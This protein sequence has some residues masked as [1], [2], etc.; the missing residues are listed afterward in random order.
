M[1]TDLASLG[2]ISLGYPNRG[3]LFNGVQM[4]ESDKWA[5]TER[6]AAYGTQETIDSIARAIEKVHAKHPNSDKVIIGHLSTKSGGRLKPHKSHQAGRDVDLSYFYTEKVGW[7]AYATDKNLDRARTWTFVKAFLEDPNTEM[8]L[9]DTSIQKMLY[10]FA[11]KAGEDKEFLDKA[12]QIA[13]KNPRAIV[14]HV[15]GHA[16]HIH[17][18]FFSPSAQA[19]GRLAEAY[20]PK[21]PPPPP[22]KRGKGKH[23]AKGDDT[24]DTKHAKKAKSGGDKKP[25]TTTPSS[26]TALEAATRSTPSRA[27]TGSRFRPSVKR[28]GS[29]QRPQAEADVPHPE[30][31]KDRKRLRARWPE[32]ERAPPK[33]AGRCDGSRPTSVSWAQASPACARRRCAPRSD[34]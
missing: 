2:P 14:R 26:I 15:A 11:L 23:V 8:V 31:R 1:K 29:R 19:T 5:F 17:A 10:D 20:L 16:T 3:R 21:P 24:E 13:G 7:Y 22:K 34:A 12:F 30:A 4:P 18:R 6:T 27:T 28:T 25:R 9:V 33:V 32:Q